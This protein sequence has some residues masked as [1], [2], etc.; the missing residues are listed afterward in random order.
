LR[1][2]SFSVD[3]GKKRFVVPENNILCIPAKTFVNNNRYFRRKDTTFTGFS[4]VFGYENTMRM[5]WKS[6]GLERPDFTALIRSD[7]P[8]NPGTL[9][10]PRLGYFYPTASPPHASESQHP[11]GLILGSGLNNNDYSGR[12]FYR[13]KFGRT[14]YE[15]VHPIQLEI[16]NEV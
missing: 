1:S 14:I 6:S 9:V 11:Y 15:R 8:Y 4:S 16:V 12:E 7:N 2:I 3:K 10:S 5:M 13:V